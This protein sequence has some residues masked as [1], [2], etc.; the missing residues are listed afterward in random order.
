M[1]NIQQP[2]G[3]PIQ[4]SI[5][6]TRDLP[7]R[8][9]HQFKEEGDYLICPCG[10]KVLNLKSVQDGIMEGM[11]S[12]GVKYS[13]RSDRKR[14]FFP[15]EWLKFIGTVKNKRNYLYYLTLLHTG[16]RAM[17]AL[18]LRPDNF[19]IERGTITFEVVKQRKAKRQFFAIGKTRT[20]FVSM[21]YLKEVKAYILKN[22]IGDKQYLFLDNDKLPSNYPELSNKEKMKYYSQRKSC[23]SSMFKRKLK[24]AGIEDWKNFSLHNIRKTYGNWMRIYD[25]RT[26]EICYRLGHDIGTYL[27]HYGSPMIFTPQE[28]IQIMNILGDVK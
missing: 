2:Q 8:H 5:S 10:K 27:V 21:K 12:N 15:A 24:K 25:I 6:L 23:Y 20:F 4:Q 1:E 13:V 22:N 18:H 19:N 9:T 16:A 3:E 11:K 17:E 7:R 26:E 14:Y 28:K